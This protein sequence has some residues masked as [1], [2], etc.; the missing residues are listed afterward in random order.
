MIVPVLSKTI[1]S[2]RLS[3]SSDSAFLIKIP[4]SAP[5]PTPTVIA[6]GVAR[7]RA[8]G[9]AITSTPTNERMPYWT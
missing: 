7:P 5:L 4:C 3:R 1:V 8:Q 2:M 6:V 9:Q